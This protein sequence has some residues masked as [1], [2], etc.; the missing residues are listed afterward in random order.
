MGLQIHLGVADKFILLSELT[1]EYTNFTEL[2]RDTVDCLWNF[3]YRSE[4]FITCRKQDEKNWWE[5]AR[6]PKT[7][8][9][10]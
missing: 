5:A 10:G 9:S 6:R 1:P 7:Y 3:G 2:W 8:L 4:E